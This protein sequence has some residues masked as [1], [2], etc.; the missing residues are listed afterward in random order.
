MRQRLLLLIVSLCSSVSWGQNADLRLDARN[1]VIVPLS[2]G[3]NVQFCSDVGSNL[4]FRLA[5]DSSGAA[6][7]IDLAANSLI[8]TLT[9]SGNTFSPSGTTLTTSFTLADSSTASSTQYIAAPGTADFSW[10]TALNFNS[11]GSTTIEIEIAVD[12]NTD[13]T[14]NNTVTYDLNILGNPNIPVLTSNYGNALP[15]NIC[16]GNTVILTASSVG[17]EYQFFRNNVSMGPRQAGNTFTTT[18]INDNDAI[19]VIAYFTNG[20]GRASTN[21]FFNVDP[22]PSGVLS[23]DAPN[24]TVCYGED[25]LFTASGAGWYEF[26]VNGTSQAASST[27]TT[28]NLSNVTTDNIDVTVRSWTNSST[29]CY[30]E[31]VI[32]IRLNSLSGSS[33]VS[34]AATVCEGIDPAALNSVSIFSAD[35]VGATLSHQWQSR[36][37]S[38]T[39]TDIS[40]ATSITYDPGVLSSTTGF[41]RLTYSTFNGVQCPTNIASAT[42]NVVTVTVTPNSIPVLTT[43]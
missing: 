19:N 3:S 14:A 38:G 29:L 15:V 4:T 11:T 17:D 10:P 23:S 21:L 7:V 30:D 5:N 1:Q 16:T 42:S 18:G 2:G 27:T 33:I 41:R 43:S 6:N 34:G 20:C 8:V 35:R 32:T 26:L 24:D 13:P 37:S 25:V 39:F 28:F 36:T 12:G 9:V 31:D 40:G 22:A